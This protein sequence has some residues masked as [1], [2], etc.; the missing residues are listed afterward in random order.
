MDYALRKNQLKDN[1]AT[2][3]SY[4]LT[5]EMNSRGALLICN[6]ANKNG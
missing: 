1:L 6:L 5:M 2:G 4:I 3:N